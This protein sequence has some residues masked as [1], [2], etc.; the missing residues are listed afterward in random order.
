MQKLLLVVYFLKENESSCSVF[1]PADQSI[2]SSGH[3]M[4]WHLDML[5]H[6]IQLA[7]ILSNQRNIV[8]Q[9]G[10]TAQNWAIFWSQ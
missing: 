1:L 6:F 10:A 9:P 4:E 8:L 5:M 3:G 2:S 7:T